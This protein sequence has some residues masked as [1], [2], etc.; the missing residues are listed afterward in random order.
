MDCDIP[1]VITLSTHRASHRLDRGQCGMTTGM[2]IRGQ[3]Y[4][5]E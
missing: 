1:Y 3:T 5:S 2:S 4:F